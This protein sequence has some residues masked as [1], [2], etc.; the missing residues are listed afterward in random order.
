M[1]ATT[2]K[3]QSLMRYTNTLGTLNHLCARFG[4]QP[5][6]MCTKLERVAGGMAC[7]IEHGADGIIRHTGPTP[8]SDRASDE[9]V[10]VLWTEENASADQKTFTIEHPDGR[11][12]ATIDTNHHELFSTIM[13]GIIKEATLAKHLSEQ[14]VIMA[15]MVYLFHE[16]GK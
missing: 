16:G 12:T 13:T 8:D 5:A 9:V 7:L 1:K 2:R 6:G 10:E 14:A 15:E 4:L 11:L 3:L